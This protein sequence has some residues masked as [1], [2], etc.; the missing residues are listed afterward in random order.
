MYS[1]G[2]SCVLSMWDVGCQLV[3]W[4][5]S[6]STREACQGLMLCDAFETGGIGLDPTVLRWWCHEWTLI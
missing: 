2:V 4:H 1:I 5:L 3:R 6:D